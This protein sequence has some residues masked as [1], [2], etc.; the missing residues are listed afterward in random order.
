MNREGH[1]LQ[2]LLLGVHTDVCLHLNTPQTQTHHNPIVR[3]LSLWHTTLNK[4]SYGT[5]VINL[6]VFS[7]YSNCLQITHGWNLGVHSKKSVLYSHSCRNTQ[8]NDWIYTENL[9]CTLSMRILTCSW[10][11]VFTRMCLHTHTHTSRCHMTTLR[12]HAGDIMSS[13]WPSQVTGRRDFTLKFCPGPKIQPCDE[14]NQ[15]SVRSI[16][17]FPLMISVS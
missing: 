4:T 3:P 16:N 2:S 5:E 1:S 15:C 6:A 7:K 10:L 13:C 9:W 8:I 11:I 14:T 12:W 17:R